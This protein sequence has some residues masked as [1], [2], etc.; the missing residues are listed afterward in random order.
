MENHINK[1]HPRVATPHHREGQLIPYDMAAALDLGDSE[2]ECI[3]VP[4][5]APWT[6]LGYQH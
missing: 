6:F 1:A 5:S 2:E 3:G 4:K